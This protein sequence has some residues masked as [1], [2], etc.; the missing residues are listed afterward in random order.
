[1][2]VQQQPQMTLLQMG[3]GGPIY[4]P[5]VASEGCYW[6]PQSNEAHQGGLNTDVALSLED[7]NHSL[8]G[9]TQTQTTASV[10]CK[11]EGPGTIG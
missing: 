5:V 9:M 3:V 10:I 1:M 4:P 8:C 6:S 7:L 2:V 11:T